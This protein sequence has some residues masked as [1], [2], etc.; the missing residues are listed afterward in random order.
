MEKQVHF[1]NKKILFNKNIDLPESP[2]VYKF[3]N[4]ENEIIYIGKA[5]NIKNRVKS[6]RKSNEVEDYFKRIDLPSFRKHL[7]NFPF[8]SNL[9]VDNTLPT[10]VEIL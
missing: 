8:G 4:S 5:K 1:K 9:V 6:Y 10:F 2:G 3:F 7:S